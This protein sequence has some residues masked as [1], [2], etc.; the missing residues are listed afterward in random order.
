VVLP[1]L[2]AR[3]GHVGPVDVRAIGIAI[4][5]LGGGRTRPEDPIDPTVGAT[6]I[7]TS[8]E[9]VGPDRP[10]ALVHARDAATAEA[11]AAAI[12]SAVTIVDEAAPPPDPIADRVAGDR[13][14]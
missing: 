13:P 12:R 10:L 3:A 8:G 2:P 5:A 1:V 14:A 7:A 9:A 6:D 4:L 11:A